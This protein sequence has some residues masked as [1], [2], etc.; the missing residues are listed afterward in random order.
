MKEKPIYEIYYDEEADFLEVFFGEPSKCYADEIEDGV[1]IRKDE[2]TNE[3][4]S[5]EILGFK[6]RTKLL[7]EVL[8]K[9]NI[10]FPL[11][12]SI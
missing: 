4:K 12:I 7:R 2:E 11:H 1:F 6:K 5:I 3:I 10:K 8:Q 9:I